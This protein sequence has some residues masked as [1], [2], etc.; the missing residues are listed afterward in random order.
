MDSDVELPRNWYEVMRKYRNMYDWFECWRWM[1]NPDGS[2]KGWQQTQNYHKRAY[3]GSQMGRSS[4]LKEIVS[5]IDDDYLYRSED[6]AIQDMLEAAG[7]RYGRVK[8][9]Y[10][11]HQLKPKST[12]KHIWKDVRTVVW[13]IKGT[14]K[15]CRPRSYLLKAVNGLVKQAIARKCITWMDLIFWTLKTNPAWVRHLRRPD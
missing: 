10:H 14:I 15:Y 1:I 11:K 6:I 2:D 3:S 7:Y 4:V 9:T 8:E 13:Q 12:T 5:Q